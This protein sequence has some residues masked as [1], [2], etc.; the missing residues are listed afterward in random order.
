MLTLFIILWLIC[1]FISYGLQFAYFQR[2]WPTL[3]KK[4]YKKD[5]IEELCLD[6]PLGAIALLGTIIFQ[7]IETGTVGKYGFKIK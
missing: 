7:L 5:M 4:Y 2:R 6:I 1:G 3:A